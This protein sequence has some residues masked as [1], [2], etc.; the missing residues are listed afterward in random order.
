MRRRGYG[1]GAL[2]KQKLENEKYKE[3]ANELATQQLEML[4]KQLEAFHSNLE[5]FA[6]KHKQVNIYR[7]YSL[8][9]SINFFCRK[10]K[11]TQNFG[12]TFKK[13]VPPSV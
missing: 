5:E 4:S 1:A 10:S 7:I 3:K 8:L 9:I 12:I 6:A 13:C 2:L 11:K